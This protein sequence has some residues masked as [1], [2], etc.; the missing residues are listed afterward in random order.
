MIFIIISYSHWPLT[1]RAA[2][3]WRTLRG[4]KFSCRRRRRWLDNKWNYSTHLAAVDFL[5]GSGAANDTD[6]KRRLSFWWRRRR[7]RLR[8]QHQDILDQKS[9]LFLCQ[10]ISRRLRCQRVQVSRQRGSAA[11]QQLNCIT[12][13]VQA[14]AE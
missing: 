1:L 10:F 11:S 6:G 9:T 3:E 5:V 13:S 4:E 8:R 7:R 14:L 12:F 2:W